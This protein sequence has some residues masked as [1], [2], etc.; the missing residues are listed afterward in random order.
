MNTQSSGRIRTDITPS[1]DEIGELF[2]QGDLV[3]VYRRLLADLETPVSVYMKLSQ[4]SDVSFLLES[5]EGGEHVGRY[6]F[7]GVN[8]QAVITFKGDTMHHTTDGQTTTRQL[9]EDEDPLHALKAELNRV[10]PVSLPKL[11]RLVGGAVGY[12]G[13][14]IVRYFERLPQTAEDD[15]DMPTAAF[16]LPDTLV[17][18]DH[19]KHELIVMANAHNQGDPDSAYRDAVRRVDQIVAALGKPLPPV[20]YAN[21]P[22]DEPMQSNITREKFETNVRQAK[23][24]I[25]A[26]DAFQIVLSQR[27]TRRT[28]AHPLTIYRAVRALNPSPYMFYLNFGDGMTLLGASPEMMVRLEDGIASMRPI[29]GTRK[30]GET[31]A[32]DRA[33]AEDLLADPKERAEHV[34]LIDLARNDI[35]RVSEYGTVKVSSMM[36]VEL[37]SHV[38]HIV[39]QVDG[40]V[41]ENIDG[42][43]LFRATFPAGTLSGAPKVRAMEIIEEL[44]GVRR[45]TYGGAVGYFSYDGS[46]DTC[47]TIRALVM[48]GDRI[49]LQA[50]AG[51]VADSDPAKEYEETV[52]KAR[53]LAVAIEYAERGLM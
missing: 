15:L 16:M 37:Y 9:A 34:M 47:I 48:R 14:D 35:G 21:N 3:P 30:R 22:L 2:K 40:Q 51:I 13:Y 4:V 7:L 8:P 26:G 46:M 36:N 52:N 42:F 39:S 33:L 24:Y 31:D 28:N 44:E 20:E 45:G 10:T 1:R 27:F 43:D 6:S 29:A 32:E 12:V 18:F 41:R 5:V 49:Y 53:A 50:G 11:P 38:M 19:A 23:E 17:I 25:A